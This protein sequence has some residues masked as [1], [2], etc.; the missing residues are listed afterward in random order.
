MARCG[1]AGSGGCPCFLADG[2]GTAVSGIGSAENPY[3][4]DVTGSAVPD[5]VDAFLTL[6][7]VTVNPTLGT[8]GTS[9]VTYTTLGNR[10]ILNGWIEFGTGLTLGTGI[11]QFITGAPGLAPPAYPMIVGTGAIYDS[12][13][14]ASTAMPIL[15]VAAFTNGFFRFYTDAG[16]ALSSTYTPAIAAGDRITFTATYYV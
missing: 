4:V 16:T 2:F 8:G 6:Q 3:T 5:G 12:S 11:W 7:G 9:G 14:A 13:L 1:C 15:S 10:I